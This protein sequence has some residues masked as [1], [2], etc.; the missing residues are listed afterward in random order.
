MFQ[1]CPDFIVWI[2]NLYFRAAVIVIRSQKNFPTVCRKILLRH[3][4]AISSLTKP[5]RRTVLNHLKLFPLKIGNQIPVSRFRPFREKQ[6]S[7]FFFAH[8]AQFVKSD[9]DNIYPLQNAPNR[10]AGTIAKRSNLRAVVPF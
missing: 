3:A 6:I 2:V 1:F 7:K 8:S 4:F 9:T 10:H 5:Y